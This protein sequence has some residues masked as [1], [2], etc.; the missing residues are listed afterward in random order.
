MFDELKL[1]LLDW[2]DWILN[3]PVCLDRVENNKLVH[4]TY[5]FRTKTRKNCPEGRPNHFKQCRSHPFNV[6]LPSKW[7]SLYSPSKECKKYAEY[8]S[9]NDL[10]EQHWNIWWNSH[11]D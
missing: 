1:Y 9:P 11:E 5:G 10:C 8:N 7:K 4:I 2:M 6:G 3:T